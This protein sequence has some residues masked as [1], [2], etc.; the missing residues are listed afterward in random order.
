VVGLVGGPANGLVFVVPHMNLPKFVGV[1]FP[2]FRYQP[3]AGNG[4][5]RI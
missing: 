2:V 1:G 4:E 5:V 3:E